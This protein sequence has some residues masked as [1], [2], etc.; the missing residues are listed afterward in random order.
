MGRRMLGVLGGSATLCVPLGG[1]TGNVLHGLLRSEG[2][3]LRLVETSE[4]SGLICMI[5]AVGSAARCGA[6]RFGR[7]AGTPLMICT[8]RRWRRRSR[9]ACAS[10]RAQT[11][12]SGCFPP[13][14]TRGLPETCMPTE[15]SS[16]ATCRAR[17][18]AHH[19][20][21]ESIW[22][23][24][25]K[26]SCSR[27]A[28][29]ASRHREPHRRPPAHF[30]RRCARR[31]RLA[32][33]RRSAAAVDGG[34]FIVRAPEMSVVDPTGAGDSM[35]AAL[36]YGRSQACSPREAL[37]LAAAAGAIN[38]TRH[39]LGS[40]DHDAITQL[41]ANVEVTPIQAAPA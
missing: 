18:C 38:V 27:T 21:V 10:S 2:F 36:A 22:S 35:T 1:E 25:A 13:R 11:A 31:R 7:S 5:G 24:S 34:L 37:R 8:A 14:R 19:S 15:S 30:T 23:R 39:G 20:R 4:A 3:D 16:C 32:G 9:P 40:G 6:R 41:A 28:G 12:S 33:C 26:T 17:C 29:R